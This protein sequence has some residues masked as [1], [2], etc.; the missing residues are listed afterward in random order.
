M[1]SWFRLAVI[2]RLKGTDVE[3]MIFILFKTTLM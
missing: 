3:V 2:N 1:Q